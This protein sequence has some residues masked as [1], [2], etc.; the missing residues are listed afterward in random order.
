ML[1]GFMPEARVALQQA[2][3]FIDAPAVAAR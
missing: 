3:A 1:D 2:A